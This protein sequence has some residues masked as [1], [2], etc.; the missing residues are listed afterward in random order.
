MFE[1][2]EPQTTIIGE[3]IKLEGDFSGEGDF[4]LY[5]ELKGN[6]TISGRLK[7]GVKSN[8]VA[9]IIAS[10]AEIAGSIKGKV[11]ITNAIDILSTGNII[12]D[13]KAQQITIAKGAA[14]NG[15][16]N[17]DMKNSVSTTAQTS[18]EEKIKD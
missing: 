14:I 8:V 4:E 18:K 11:S 3:G 1:R 13:V 7:I 16:V 9:N 5:G 12:G 2:N 15:K 17:I 10:N 6:I